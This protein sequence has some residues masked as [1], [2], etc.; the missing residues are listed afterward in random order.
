MFTQE[1]DGVIDRYEKYGLIKGNNSKAPNEKMAKSA[2]AIKS[3]PPKE[4]EIMLKEYS[5]LTKQMKE[6]GYDAKVS[7]RC[8]VLARKLK[9]NTDYSP[10]GILPKVFSGWAH[11][12]NG[13]IVKA[14]MNRYRSW[15]NT[16]LAEKVEKEVKADNLAGYG[17]DK[18]ADLADS[19]V[20]GKPLSSEQKDLARELKDHVELVN[21][22]NKEDLSLEYQEA[23]STSIAF[24]DAYSKL[25]YAA[26]L[27]NLCKGKVNIPSM[28][29]NLS[30]KLIEKAFEMDRKRNYGRVAGEMNGIFRCYYACGLLKKGEE[31]EKGSEEEIKEELEEQ[32]EKGPEKGKEQGEKPDNTKDR[33]SKEISKL[34]VLKEADNFTREEWGKIPDWALARYTIN[35]NDGTYKKG[36]EKPGIVEKNVVMGSSFVQ[37]AKK[38]DREALNK[39]LDTAEELSRAEW[40]GIYDNIEGKVQEERTALEQWPENKAETQRYVDALHNK[41]KNKKDID[42]SSDSRQDFHQGR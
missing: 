29:K 22:F 37:W 41:G 8:E 26:V 34:E 40:N 38:Q 21:S 27:K 39:F 42:R 24:V 18:L 5:Y 19:V 16:R 35:I 17:Q 4:L 13:N 31:R 10:Q 2:E 20:A 33:Y 14:V 7:A 12:I 9:L 32:K 11:I 28:D 23:L 1:L 15:K 6:E 36:D 30:P 25:T 3:I